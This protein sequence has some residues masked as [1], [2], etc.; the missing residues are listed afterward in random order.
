MMPLSLNE[1][2]IE[3]L[4]LIF[5]NDLVFKFIFEQINYYYENIKYYNHY[6]CFDIYQ[7]DNNYKITLV[8]K[9]TLS[10]KEN[11]EKDDSLSI[12]KNLFLL[13]DDPKEEK[14]I[15][16]LSFNIKDNGL[17]IEKK[18][19][20]LREYTAYKDAGDILASTNNVK[21][22]IIYFYEK[23]GKIYEEG[24]K[25]E[26]EFNKFVR[27]SMEDLMNLRIETP[28]SIEFRNKY[29]NDEERNPDIHVNLNTESNKTI[30]F[31]DKDEVKDL[32]QIKFDYKRYPNNKNVFN[33]LKKQIENGKLLLTG[34]AD[35]KQYNSE[36]IKGN[37]FSHID[38]FKRIANGDCFEIRI[39]YF[40]D[41]NN[42]QSTE[43][44]ASVVEGFNC[45]YEKASGERIKLTN[46]NV[47]DYISAEEM[48]TPTILI[49]HFPKINFNNQLYK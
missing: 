42:W 19:L 18:E 6:K 27:I 12:F 31:I 45:Y 4:K 33:Y 17:F 36:L 29:F 5:K 46:E 34:E 21:E 9:D 26:I 7:D 13:T 30:Y 38:I 28:N 22:E 25:N 39:H 41:R 14:R 3:N 32:Y 2:F 47:D 40:G 44:Y 8:S 24:S 11:N 15:F 1:K 49:R 10:E 23:D 20:D 35:D 48:E 16:T 37:I 43:Y